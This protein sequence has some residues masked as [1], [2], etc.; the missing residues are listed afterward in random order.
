MKQKQLHFI[1]LD[2]KIILYPLIPELRQRNRTY[3]TCMY[4]WRLT[5]NLWEYVELILVSLAQVYQIADNRL[6]I[7]KPEM[8][9][10]KHSV[11]SF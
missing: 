5:V 4:V 3:S 1:G 7:H 9:G 8:T 2:K 10:L 6:N 11:S